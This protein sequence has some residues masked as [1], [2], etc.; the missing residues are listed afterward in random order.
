MRWRVYYVGWRGGCSFP[1]PIQCHGGRLG[2]GCRQRFMRKR[3][4]RGLIDGSLLVKMRELRK[5]PTEAERKSLVPPAPS[6]P[7]L[8]L[9]ALPYDRRLHRGF[10]L[11]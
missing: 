3:D 11:S 6:Q 1:S 9:P 5:N 8:S 10:P 2:W 7:W 4:R